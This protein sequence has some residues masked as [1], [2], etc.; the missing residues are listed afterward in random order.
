MELNE[1]PVKNPMQEESVR[2]CRI[3]GVLYEYIK[4]CDNEDNDFRSEFTWVFK[5]KKNIVQG[6]TVIENV[7][8]IWNCWWVFCRKFDNW[9]KDIKKELWPPEEMQQVN[10]FLHYIVIKYIEM[11]MS[12]FKPNITP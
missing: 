4:E 7:S 12:C 1:G 3:M 8:T 2:M 6:S 5:K 9:F 10:K 11:D